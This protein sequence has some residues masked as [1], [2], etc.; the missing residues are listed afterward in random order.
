MSL[1]RLYRIR[2]DLC[3]MEMSGLMGTSS[4]AR[5]EARR[6]GWTRRKDAEDRLIDVG[7]VCLAGERRRR[8]GQ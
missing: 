1:G 7:P 6:A 4:A 8:G 3:E 5:R 2:C